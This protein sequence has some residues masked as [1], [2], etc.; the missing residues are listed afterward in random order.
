MVDPKT[1]L[2][3][4]VILFFRYFRLYRTLFAQKDMNVWIPSM[5]MKNMYLNWFTIESNSFFEVS[6]I[7]FIDELDMNIIGDAIKK[8]QAIDDQVLPHFIHV[9]SVMTLGKLL[10][11]LPS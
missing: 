6:G 3:L 8:L 5:K 9:G 10:H 11:F 7:Y 1:T 2:V 4:T